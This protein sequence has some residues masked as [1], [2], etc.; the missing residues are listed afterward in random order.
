MTDHSIFDFSFFLIPFFSSN[1]FLHLIISL[2]RLY[3]DM[4]LRMIPLFNFFPMLF[5][6]FFFNCNTGQAIFI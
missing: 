3:I 6:F 5:V 4:L 1:F 2:N